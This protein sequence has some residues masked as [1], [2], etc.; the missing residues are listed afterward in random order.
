[1]KHEMR[2]RNWT[3]PQVI[4]LVLGTLLAG[5]GARNQSG[6]L[7]GVNEAPG[8]HCEAAESGESDPS[9]LE[10]QRTSAAASL[11]DQLKVDPSAVELVESCAVVWRD[12]ALGC[13]KPGFAYTQALVPGV[14]I[15][16]RHE[17]EVYRY[18]GARKGPPFLCADEDAESPL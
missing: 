6:G 17:D 9:D 18:H 15:V 14:L 7:E 13:P 3:A 5:C 16:L 4:A 1:M 2:Y 8:S 10:Q 12:G 11:A